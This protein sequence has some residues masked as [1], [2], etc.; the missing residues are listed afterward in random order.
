MNDMAANGRRE[1]EVIVVGLGAMGA[2]TLHQLAKRRSGVLGIDRFHPPHARGASH[3]DTRITREAVGEGP[4]YVPLVRRSHRLVADLERERGTSFL[5]R[6]GTVIIGS[7]ADEGASSPSGPDFV[8]HSIATA[9]AF[10]IEHEVLDAVEL[11]RRYPQFKAI[12]AGDRGY[13]EP[14]AGFMKPEALV[15]AQLDGARRLG[16][17]VLTGTTVQRIRQAGHGVLVETDAG[18]FEARRVVVAAGAWARTL[19]GEPY[20]SL[21]TVTRQVVHWYGVDDP[22]PFRPEAMPVFMWFVSNGRGDYFAGFPVTDRAE[23]LKMITHDEGPDID[24]EAVPPAG[25]AEA[26]AFYRR[27]VA[28]NLA[29]VGPDTIRS[30]T[31]FYTSTPDGGFIIDR[32]PAMAGVMVVCACSGHGFKHSLGVGE[33][34]AQTLLDGTSEIDL[35]PFRLSRF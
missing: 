13:F 24:H 6:C 18:T 9:R 33:A 12:A 23:G 21:L 20:A 15:A 26:M 34:V 30:A 3:G 35:A 25:E 28:P 32:H 8:G 22:S 27:Y 31:C 7:A 29:G 1:F 19:L 4:A 10:G 5:T 11:R 16:A 17:E 2:A 14:N